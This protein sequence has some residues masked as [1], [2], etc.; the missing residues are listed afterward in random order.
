MHP[1]IRCKN[2]MPDK[3][4]RDLLN[5]GYQIANGMRHLAATGVVHRDLAARNVLVRN[6]IVKISDYGLAETCGHRKNTTE[7]LPVLILAPECFGETKYFTTSS[8]V[9]AFGM[10]L[11]D[12]FNLCKEEAYQKW[13][14]PDAKTL[15][16]KLVA[17][18]RL[19]NAIHATQTLYNFMQ[20]CWSFVPETRPLFENCKSVMEAELER[21]APGSTEKL[22]KK[23]TTEVDIVMRNELN[24]L[25]RSRRLRQISV[26]MTHSF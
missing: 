13:N 5:Y 1:V 4:F 16:E 23:L 24:Q 25:S 18:N 3:T 2:M 6:G 15:H 21:C 14:L 10:L 17:G 22:K 8:D 20:K 11:W 9:W 19:E 12:I 26:I 7:L